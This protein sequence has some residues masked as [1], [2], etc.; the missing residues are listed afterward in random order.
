MKAHNV[1]KSIL[2]LFLA[3]A[4]VTSC[5]D[6][7]KTGFVKGEAVRFSVG[8]D[9]AG[10]KA[11]YSGYV[12]DNIERIDWEEN[13][14]IRIYCNAVSEPSDKFADYHVTSDITPD[15]SISKAH[16][17]V[18]GGTGLSWGEGPHTFYG[19]FPSP[20]NNGVVTGINI[21]PYTLVQA[22]SSVTTNIDGA[23]VTAKLPAK[24][25]VI[26]GVT[27]TSLGGGNY[28]AAP[29]LKNML[30][31][32]KSAEYYPETGVTD[33]VFLSFI[34][35]TTAI[36]FTIR[37]GTGA[38]LDLTDVQLISGNG[39]TSAEPVVNGTFRVD[40]DQTG[41][42]AGTEVQLGGSLATITYS[43]DYPFCYSA[44]ST[45][46]EL[47]DRTLTISVG[48]DEDPLR[49]AVG[50][51]L[52]FT[53]FLNPCHD[54]DDLT[55]KLV[56]A[57]GS[58]MS[59]RLGYTDGVGLTFPRHMKSSVYGLLVPEG[60]QWRVSFEAY[61]TP[62]DDVESGD[63]DLNYLEGKAGVIVTPWE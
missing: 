5:Q 49:L 14:L 42:A 2:A 4:S 40:L 34:P 24:Q 43:R 61:I 63:I 50:K 47:A 7:L 59:T 57:D 38:E 10:T 62:W 20:E 44:V 41:I 19:V 46:T 8:T 13:D 30:M 26:G 52:M 39:K 35:L 9:A 48:T 55:F 28:I 29:D 21:S 23:T 31:T 3:I 37:N 60:A 6:K 12:I 51:D 1:V 58:W 15:G 17:E 25:A 27:E 36:K 56:K 11:A 18:M 45:S 53:F 54:F 16:I 22:K 32:A 33:E